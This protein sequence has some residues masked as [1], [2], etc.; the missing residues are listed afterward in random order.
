MIKGIPSTGRFI[1]FLIDKS[2]IVYVGQSK[3]Y[4]LRI[5]NHL[6]DKVFDS[7]DLLPLSDDDDMDLI[8]FAYIA[9]LQPLY[10]K[11]FPSLSFLWSERQLNFAIE[12]DKTIGDILNKHA[13]DL[14]I[15]LYSGRFKFWMLTGF[16]DESDII[17]DIIKGWR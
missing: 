2:E 16:D 6:K 15:L 1:Y 9:K 7:Y 13:P 4:T 14:D 11:I 17:N 12:E 10:N 3:N 5:A 8:E